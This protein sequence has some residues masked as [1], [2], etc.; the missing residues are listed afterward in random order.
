MLSGRWIWIPTS[1]GSRRS[2]SLQAWL[3]LERGAAP[4]DVV[5]AAYKLLGTAPSTVLTATLEDALGVSERP[6]QPGTTTQWPNWRLALPRF[7]EDVEQVEVAHDIARALSR[8]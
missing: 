1:P 3:G 4:V 7:L 8:P 6:N 5:R 2:S